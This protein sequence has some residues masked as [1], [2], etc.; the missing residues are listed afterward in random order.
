MITSA[1]VKKSIK[2]SIGSGYESMEVGIVL[3][4]TIDEDSEQSPQAQIEAYTLSVDEY[5][6]VERDKHQSIIS[7]NSVFRKGAEK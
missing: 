2:F 4:F 7:E 3:D 1:Q 6:K 5:C